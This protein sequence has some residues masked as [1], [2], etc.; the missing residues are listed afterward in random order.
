M[1][2][3]RPYF[4]QETNLVTVSTD[5]AFDKSMQVINKTIEPMVIHVRPGA[6]ATE[7]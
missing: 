1:K 4:E 7:L 5:Q 3:L 6:N 2:T